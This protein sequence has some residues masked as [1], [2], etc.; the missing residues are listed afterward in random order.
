MTP[1]PPPLTQEQKTALEAKIREAVPES[2]ELKFGCL[3]APK[4][5]NTKVVRILKTKETSGV[6]DNDGKTIVWILTEHADEYTPISYYEILG[7]PLQL[8]DVLIAIRDI[9]GLYETTKYAHPP[10]EMLLGNVHCGFK[11]AYDLTKDYHRQSEE[12]LR[13][14][15]DILCA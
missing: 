5:C 15:Y 7:R 2:M 9:N 12:T 6:T 3:V 14:L 11:C 8:A 1:T 10:T 4:D 13:F